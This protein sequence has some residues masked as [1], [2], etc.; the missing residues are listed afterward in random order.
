[1]SRQVEHVLGDFYVLDPV[2]VFFLVPNFVGVSQECPINRCLKAR[3]HDVF[4]ARED[5]A[6]DLATIS[7]VRIVSR[8]TAKASWPLC[9]RDQ[10]V[11]RMNSAVDAALRNELI[12]VDRAFDSRA[13]FSARP[14]TL[15]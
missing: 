12:D 3:A 8:I 6:A 1:M 4:P 10:I 14:S 11:G 5:D 2:E 9:H 15:M 7:M 13:M